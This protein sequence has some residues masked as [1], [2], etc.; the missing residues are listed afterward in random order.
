MYQA[1]EGNG[2]TVRFASLPDVQPL[3]LSLSSV[4]PRH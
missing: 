2:G 1:I 4:V 3:A